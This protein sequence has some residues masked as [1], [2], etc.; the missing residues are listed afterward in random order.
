MGC[1]CRYATHAAVLLLLAASAFP[2]SFDGQ[3]RVEIADPSGGLSWNSTNAAL[4]VSCW[5]RIVVPS[6]VR[7]SKDMTVLVDRR[8]GG[9]GDPCAYLIEYDVLS[10]N[11]QFVTHDGSAAAT[12]ALVERPYLNRWYHVAIVRDGSVL[13]GYVDGYEAFQ[14]TIS[15]GDGVANTNGVSIG[16]WGDN[17]THFHGD[18]QEVAVYRKAL[19]Q[20]LIRDRMFEDQDG[21]S[22]LT[23]YYKLSH[24]TDP[25]ERFKSFATEVP[26]NTSPGVAAG[27]GIEFE[28]V[29]EAGEQ[30][31]FDSRKNR[32][33]E[34]L[35]PLASGFVWRHACLERPT[36]GIPFK[37]EISYSSA[38]SASGSKLG[39]FDPFEAPPLGAGWRHSFQSRVYP[40]DRT[41]ERRVLSWDGSTEIWDWNAGVRAYGTRHGEY[42]GELRELDSFDMEWTA[43]DH[44]AYTYRDPELG[45]P[46]EGRLEEISDPNSNV[47]SV[48]WNE[49]DAVITQVV[50][51]AGGRYDFLYDDARGLL[52][53]VSFEGWAVCFEYDTNK[54]LVAKWLTGPE[55]YTNAETRWEFSYNSSNL[56]TEIRDP[57]GKAVVSVAYDKYGRRIRQEDALGRATRFEYG[58]PDARQVRRTDPA[59]EKWIE[60]YDRKGRLVSRMDPLEKKTEHEYD[61]RGNVICTTEP[62]GWK[63]CYG[64]DGRANRIAETNALGLVRRW[65]YHDWFNKPVS[66]TDPLGEETRYAYDAA[67]NLLTKSDDI[68]TMATHSYY[69][70]G[71][72]RASADGNGHVTTFSYT[73]DG[74]LASRSDPASNTWTYGYNELGWTLA[75]TNPLT[76]PLNQPT[77]YSYDLNGNVTEINEPL[78]RR[79]TR[80]YD[81]AGNLLSASDARGNLTRYK[82]D[83]ANQRTQMTDRAGA[84]WGYE[85]DERGKLAA[86]IDPDGNRTERSYDRAGRLEA[87]T[88]PLP[89]GGTVEHEYDANGNLTATKDQ[90]GR[91]WRK[92]YDRLNRVIAETDPLGNTKTT[93]YD[94]AGRIGTVT[95][96]KGFPSTHEYDGRGRLERWVDAE[97][98]D[99]LYAYDGELNITN[100]TDALDDR[101]VMAYGS[102][103]ERVME[104]NQDG[105]EWGYEYD[106]LVRLSGATDPNGTV[107]TTSYDAAGRIENV[108]F[109]TGRAQNYEYDLDGNPTRIMR[110]DPPA[111]FAETE[112]TYDEMGRVTSYEGP[113]QKQ[114]GYEYDLRGLVSKLTYPGSKDLDQ[115]YD[116][117]GRL[118]LQRD[119]QGRETRYAYDRA[120]RL[121]SREYPNGI[122]QTNAYDEAGRM[123]NLAYVG[124]ATN[125]LIA[126]EYAYDGNG[127]KSGHYEKGTLRWT[128]GPR[129]DRSLNH[130]PAGRL[131]DNSDAFDAANALSYA[132]DEAGNLTNAVGPGRSMAFEYDEDNR[133]TSVAWRKGATTHSIANRY[134]A[135]GRRVSRTLDGTETKYVL[136]LSGRMERILCDTDSSGSVRAYYVHGPDLCYKVSASGKLSCYHADAQANIVATTD[137]G[138]EFV[139]R[140]AYAPYG[141]ALGI[142]GARDD[143][144][145]FVGSQGVMDELPGEDGAGLY[146]MRARYYSAD[147]A[148]FLSTDPVKPIG[149]GW[150]PVVYSYAGSSPLTYGDPKGEFIVFLTLLLGHSA[151]APTSPFL[152]STGKTLPLNPYKMIGQQAGEELGK[153]MI[154][155]HQAS[156]TESYASYELVDQQFLPGGISMSLVNAN[157]QGTS[158][159]Q[160]EDVLD[161]SVTDRREEIK[162]KTGDAADH[163]DDLNVVQSE[164]GGGGGGGRS[165]NSDGRD[166]DDEGSFWDSVV[167]TWNSIVDWFKDLFD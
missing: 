140:Y 121:V 24:A 126:L 124:S 144:Y 99:W 8:E 131:T 148:M 115:E 156:Q 86:E 11:L 133:V 70:N 106:E 84:A 153:T 38:L 52:T 75:V 59:G 2:A 14:D 119:W 63:T 125:A 37:L 94:A 165:S 162:Q 74:F 155:I 66:E 81:A 77:S 25:A 109:S 151:P 69:S 28:E 65:E 32:G 76:P 7:I 112:F 13:D 83:G 150:K 108:I 31:L 20:T 146:F 49:D 40:P 10:G 72:V 116:A 64:Y 6:D 145:R 134:D 117:L 160:V 157:G 89:L 96:P 152:A 103:N 15:V 122:V 17:G 104:R 73:P 9:E 57:A 107:R 137:D 82:Y 21:L 4:T 34:R 62:L 118:V 43:P 135:L 120:N 147:E 26:T 53:N 127:N 51:T 143:P 128:P 163:A 48:L 164:S 88:D 50:D 161:S 166:G 101:Y 16:G 79:F 129:I 158:S 67:G 167:D 78:G 60:E 139:S 46:M 12:N 136:D 91:W 22:L 93:S 97:G 105:K 1:R 130:T 29:D 159:K 54:L 47:V 123:T 85:H 30:S 42:R 98:D 3:S 27:D 56:L 58:V 23:G 36:P 80:T 19:S 55:G 61:G 132:Y 149:P 111:R 35:T 92:E 110:I 39:E 138:E 154:K 41:R 100:I 33:S 71:L 5:L 141:K 102:R 18:I 87:I 44:T 113:Y 114:V 90:T 45:D 68:G 142:E 95:T